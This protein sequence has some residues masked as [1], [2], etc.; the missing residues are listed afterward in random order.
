MVIPLLA[1]QD[2]TPIP[3]GSVVS[4]NLFSYLEVYSYNASQFLCLRSGFSYLEILV[5]IV[6]G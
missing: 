1:N 2:L 5:L 6:F 4:F 3:L